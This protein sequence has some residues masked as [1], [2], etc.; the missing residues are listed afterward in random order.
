MLS[1]GGDGLGPGDLRLAFCVYVCVLC[2]LRV[3]LNQTSLS[4]LVFCAVAYCGP[5]CSRGRGMNQVKSSLFS[6][7]DCEFVLSRKQWRH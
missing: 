7:V 3:I 6:V 4:R 1:I 5:I 2:C